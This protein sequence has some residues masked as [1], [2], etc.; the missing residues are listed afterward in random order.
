MQGTQGYL[1][2]GLLIVL[3]TQFG[4]VELSKEVEDEITAKMK[5]DKNFVGS[6]EHILHVLKNSE[7]LKGV[8]GIKYLNSDTEGVNFEL[9]GSFTKLAVKIIIYNDKKYDRCVNLRVYNAISARNLTYVS[10][11]TKFEDSDFTIG[12]RKIFFCLAIYEYSFTTDPRVIL[13][14]SPQDQNTKEENTRKLFLFI[15]RTIQGF[16]E[17]HFEGKVLHGDVKPQSIMVRHDTTSK[18]YYPLIINFDKM[19]PNPNNQE[20]KDS[21][22]RYDWHYRPLE[23]AGKRSLTVNEEDIFLTKTW[24]TISGNMTYSN[25]FL[26]DVSALGET[27][28]K[29]I[30]DNEFYINR[31]ICQIKKL[32]GLTKEMTEKCYEIINDN[33]VYRRKYIRKNMRVIFGDFIKIAKSCKQDPYISIA[34]TFI[35]QFEDSLKSISKNILII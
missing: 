26:E 1:I 9:T 11:V 7:F 27:I 19:L 33:N 35:Q 21:K 5:A 12:D 15:G 20:I 16:A 23:I 25:E 8:K 31:S 17:L 28:N 13:T 10:K 32:E 34:N 6:V 24:P 30:V 4:A 18:A 3:V 22:L 29:I 2:A 14:I